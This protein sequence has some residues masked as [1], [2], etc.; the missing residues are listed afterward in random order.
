MA[1]RSSIEW[2]DATW[3]P[4][5]G[6]SRVSEG[7]RNCY[8][9]NVAARFSG[10]GLPYEGLIHPSTRAW[11]GKVRLVD[12]VLEQPLR[13]RRPRRIFVNSMSDLFHDNVPFDYVDRVMAVMALAERHT[14]QILTKRPARMLEYFRRLAAVATDHRNKKGA[15]TFDERG[16]LNFRHMYR[17]FGHAKPLPD[18]WPLPNVWLGVSVENQDAAD[19][20]IPLLLQVPACVR[21]LS[22]EPL[23][24]PISFRWTPYAHQA[25]GQTP[26]DYLDQHGRVN[27]LEA[28]RKLNWVVVGGE[29]GRA[30]RPMHPEWARAIRSQCEEAEVPFFFKQWGEYVP[31]AQSGL[32]LNACYDHSGR[33]GW[34][35]LDGSF[36]LGEE[37]RPADVASSAHVFRLGKQLAGRLLDG[38]EHNAYP[39]THLQAA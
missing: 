14:F 25:S 9:E 31:H 29:S 7:C 16:V 5:R 1:D 4:V 34:V 17:H 21:W 3:N 13:W 32:D 24:G 26:G 15:P 10:A 36:S 38:Q 2:T 18:V 23:L 22:C 30:A 8:A 6:C 37:A 33:G 12:D 28:L 20:R 19:E 39:I 35:E 27:H 11:N